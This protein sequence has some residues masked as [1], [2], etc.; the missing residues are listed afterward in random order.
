MA[1]EIKRLSKVA[2]EFNVALHTIVDFLASKGQKIESN[3]NAKLSPA[4]Y[5]I[6][7]DQ[8][9]DEKKDKDMATSISKA[10]AK[11]EGMEDVIVTEPVKKPTKEEQEEILI[12]DLQAPKEGVKKKVKEEVKEEVI[13]AKSEKLEV[14]VKGKIDLDSLSKS[15]TEKKGKKKEEPEEK[16]KAKKTT[17]KKKGE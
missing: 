17:K 13:K 4:Q 14:N 10:K 2:K 15:K 16:G 7:L 3:P 6:L 1:E 12:K 11:R 5:E 8:F 9:S